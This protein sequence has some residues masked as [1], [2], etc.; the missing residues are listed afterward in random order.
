MFFFLF[1]F[2]LF[3]VKVD[4]RSFRIK[5][6]FDSKLVLV[7]TLNRPFF[8]VSPIDRAGAKKYLWGVVRVIN[9]TFNFVPKKKKKKKSLTIF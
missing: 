4:Y 3:C 1:V 2:T 6:S 5:S 7:G 9:C 8:N